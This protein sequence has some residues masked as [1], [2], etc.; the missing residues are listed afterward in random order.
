MS[1]TFSGG[2]YDLNLNNNATAVFIDL[3]ILAVS[4]LVRAPW[5]FRFAALLTLQDQNI[6]GRGMVGFDLEDIDW[7]ATPRERARNKEFVLRTV[8]LALSRHRWEELRYEP[9]RAPGYLRDF[10]SMVQAFEPPDRPGT[11]TDFPGPHEAAMASCVQHRVLN[12][13]PHWDACI[14]CTQ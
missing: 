1:N 10:H 14:F 13:L 8:G 7:G 6:M 5:D 11:A 3:L 9:A 12:A 2:D 4:D